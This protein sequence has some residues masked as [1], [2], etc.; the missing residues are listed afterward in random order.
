MRLSEL[1]AN[2]VFWSATPTT[3]WLLVTRLDW[4][5]WQAGLAALVTGAGLALLTSLVAGLLD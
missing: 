2:L 4:A 3:G 1:L 5:L